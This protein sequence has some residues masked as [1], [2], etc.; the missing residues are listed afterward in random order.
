MTSPHSLVG[1]GS[2]CGNSSCSHVGLDLEG[3]SRD[4][5]LMIRLMVGV[6]EDSCVK[7]AGSKFQVNK[8]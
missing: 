4:N 3:N 6:P 5:Q 2:G 8:Y 7:Q 1:L